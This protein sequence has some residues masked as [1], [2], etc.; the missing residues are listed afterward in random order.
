M[1]TFGTASRI[2]AALVT[3]AALGGVQIASVPP[4]AAFL[5]L[6]RTDGI[7]GLRSLDSPKSTQASCP[8]GKVVVGGGAEIEGGG[9]DP[10]TQPR[11]TR[12]LPFFFGFAVTAE[13][14]NHASEEIWL[15]R[16]Y[17]IC[18]DA[19]ALDMDR[20]LIVPGVSAKDSQSFKDAEARCPDGTVAFGAGGMITYPDFPGFPPP[21]RVGLQLVRPSGPLDIA[22]ATGREYGDG[23]EDGYLGNWQV[24][25]WAICAPL[26]GG[27]H[28]EGTLGQV[29]GEKST[30]ECSNGTLAASAGGGGGPFIDGGDAYLQYIIPSEEL[31]H[32]FVR[33]TQPLDPSVGGMVASATCAE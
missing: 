29:D 21:A 22:R 33:L 19:D 13:A 14:P 2:A 32:V 24:I 15:V 9:E 27:L 31:T 25:A 3:L 23:V 1:R 20:Y 11:L 7:S 16:A 8:P 30:H 10:A 5:A 18:A 12:L 26:A 17:A 4:A 6:E 28:A